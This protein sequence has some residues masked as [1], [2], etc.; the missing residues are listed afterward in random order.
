MHDAQPAAHEP[1]SQSLA[2][3][4][5]HT[6]AGGVVTANQLLEHTGGRGIY[7]VFILLSLP[8]VLWV[9]LPGMSTILGLMIG[10][11]A[12]RRALNKPPRLPSWLG[13]RRLP[14]RLKGIILGG[15]MKMC[16]AL[17]KVSRPR[18]TKWLAWRSVRA[19][20]A[21]LICAMAL[22]LA[23]PLPSPPFFGSNAFPSYAIILLAVAMMEEDGVMIWFGYLASLATVAYFAA[24]G[25][26]I[27]PHLIKWFRA[28]LQLLETTQ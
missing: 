18:K 12:F 11:L 22:L 2:R 24:W 23:L 21:V 6:G 20:N 14:P 25:G 7:F 27:L 19:A 28:L 26:V 4:L 13:D 15:G 5:E 10:L 17:E 16:R 9:S 3:I 1:L 8:F